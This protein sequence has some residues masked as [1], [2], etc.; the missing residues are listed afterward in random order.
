MKF[1]IPSLGQ[2]IR[3]KTD[4][5]F[6][7]HSEG[8]NA[9]LLEFDTAGAYGL[10]PDYSSVEQRAAMTKAGYEP[11]PGNVWRKLFT[12]PAGTVLIVD[13]I[14]IRKSAT[15]FNSVSFTAPKET[16]PD[17]FSALRAIPGKIRFWAKL[18]DVNSINFDYV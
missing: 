1:N 10:Y 7:L 12:L 11:A 18:D 13:R 5:T 9:A 3:L 2:K 6:F 15:D 17:K 4:W 14:Y 8:R 16:I